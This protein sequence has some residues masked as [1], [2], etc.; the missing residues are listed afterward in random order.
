MRL[1]ENHILRHFGRAF[2]SCMLMLIFLFVVIDLF[3]NINQLIKYSINP[4]YLLAYYLN[5]IPYVATQGMPVAILISVVYV[6]VQFNRNNEITAMRA[7][8]ISIWHILRPLIACGFMISIASFIISD[9]IVPD[10]MLRASDL[11]E[12]NFEKVKMEKQQK[13]HEKILYN[14]AFY[15]T[16][17]RIFYAHEYSVYQNKIS[18][19]IIH[20]QDNNQE[21]VS[22]TTATEAVWKNNKWVAKNAMYFKLSKEGKIL[23]EPYFYEEEALNID[24]TPADFAKRRHQTEYM[25]FAEL[26]QYIY[27]LSFG[28]SSAVLKLKVDLEHKLAFPFANVVVVFIAAPFALI[29]GRHKSALIGIAMVAIILLV[30]SYYAVMSIALAMGKAGIMHPIAAAWFANVVFALGGTIVIFRMK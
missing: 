27:Y 11:K 22:K 12:M 14:V 5:F 13:K 25:S 9:R 6:F 7:S 20:E 1:F 30:L 19:L 28:S 23:E 15:G 4:S 2:I 18:D 29:G 24:E 3:D 8:G 10:S 16:H 21:V 17:N 26:K